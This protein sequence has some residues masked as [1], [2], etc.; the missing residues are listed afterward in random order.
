MHG[1][2]AMD[3]PIVISNYCMVLL[4]KQEKPSD[5]IAL[6]SF[7]YHVVKTQKT[8]QIWS[9]NSYTARGLKWTEERLINAKKRLMDLGLIEQVRSQKEHGGFGKVYLR[10]NFIWS[11]E[12]VNE[13]MATH[14]GKHTPR[15]SHAMFDQGS[16]ALSV[17]E[18]NADMD[19][20]EDFKK[21]SLSHEKNSCDGV[22]EKQE[23]SPLETL[24][25]K[26]DEIEVEA[27]PP[28]RTRSNVFPT[29]ADM[30]FVQ[31]AEQL[32]GIVK[33]TKNIKIDKRQTT[34]WAREIKR[35]CRN[36]NPAR[37]RRALNWYAEN[38]GR[39]YVPDIQSGRS[40]LEKFHKLEGAIERDKTD[41]AFAE[42]KTK[43]G[44]SIPEPPTGKYL[45]ALQRAWK[46]RFVQ[47]YPPEMDVY[48]DH[49]LHLVVGSKEQTG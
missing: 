20:K 5:L 26:T 9:T 41:S 21:Q 7:Y 15:K 48:F 45:A 32:A 19:R 14:Q 12:K 47:P 31:L 2:D 13:K 22:C 4:L 42:S 18:L 28:S 37:V 33:S 17:L 25:K 3:E 6:Y 43:T 35:L 23:I 24:H 49:Y 30:V 1:Y 10:V 16:N 38:V 11:M 46:N 8:H 39:Q 29:E 44:Q 34:Q 36:C 40:L 27:T